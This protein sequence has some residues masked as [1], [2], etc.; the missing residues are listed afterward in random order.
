VDNKQPDL[1]R[2]EWL[3]M[4]ICWRGRKL[5]A[6]QVYDEVAARRDWEYQTVK[7]MLDRLVQKRYLRREKLGPLCL[8]QPVTPRTK[9]VGG[10][11]ESFVDTVLDNTLGSLF[12]HLAKGRKLKPEELE[13]LKRLVAEC[14]ET[15]PMQ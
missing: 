6:R 15:D 14:E 2:S 5:T 3:L 13:E 1:S 11:I 8:Y 10:A 9:A 4:N 7:T 12:V